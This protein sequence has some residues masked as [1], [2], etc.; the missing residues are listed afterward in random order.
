[1]LFNLYCL[2]TRLRLQCNTSYQR[3]SSLNLVSQQ[4]KLC[5]IFVFGMAYSLSYC[6]LFILF[7]SN[8]HFTMKLVFFSVGGGRVS[9]EGFSQILDE[10]SSDLK[11]LT[12]CK[13]LEFGY[14]PKL[15][16][17]VRQ[18]E[19]LENVSSDITSQV[20][21]MITESN[22]QL[23]APEEFAFKYRFSYWQMNTSTL[24]LI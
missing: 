17:A 10:Q 19:I 18:L 22:Q 14:F 23:S 20:Q 8:E 7:T 24:L 6:D 15:C 1:M 4:L 11:S 9:M 16:W 5:N 21:K 12:I 13:N 3:H 2:K